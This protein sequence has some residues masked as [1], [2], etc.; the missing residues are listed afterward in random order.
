M[1]ANTERSR[2]VVALG[3][4]RGTAYLPA[5]LASMARQ[6]SPPD[7]VVICDDA[8]GDATP[9]CAR[10]ELQR[11]GLA[12]EVREQPQNLRSTRNFADAIARVVD[13]AGADVVVLADQDDVWAPNKLERLSTA[14]RLHPSAAFAFSDAAMVDDRL[15]P[16]N[17]RLWEAVRF[18]PRQL[19][20]H[21]P[22]DDAIV[23]GNAFELLL[24]RFVVTGAT[25]AFRAKYRDLILPI[26]CEWVHDAWI[27]LLLSAVAPC[28]AVAEP[29]IQYRQHAGQQ[30]GE[31]KRGLVGQYLVAQTLGTPYVE[32]LLTMFTQARDRLASVQ[33]AGTYSV[34]QSKFDALEAKIQHLGRR[35][36]WRRGARFGRVPGVLTEWATRRY[37]RYSLGWKS[38]AHDLFL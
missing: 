34:E 22:G 28:A 14:L 33:A 13:D 27:A 37:G 38:V 7:F 5:Q 32:R 16:L 10:A 4:Y 24:R 31:K 35:L 6:T 11:L 12:G 3:A 25:M 23:A 8:S 9:N 17:Y 19:D 29:L 21:A 26:P 20:R 15:Q 36:A 2:L 18:R 30:I 1:T